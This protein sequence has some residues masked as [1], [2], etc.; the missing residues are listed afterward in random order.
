MNIFHTTQASVVH[1]ATKYPQTPRFPAT[2]AVQILQ[3]TQTY[4]YT[5][6]PSASKCN[7]RLVPA[8]GHLMFRADTESP[9]WMGHHPGCAN[10]L[11][12]LSPFLL[13]WRIS[14]MKM[15][16]NSISGRFKVEVDAVQL[17]IK[18]Q[19]SKQGGAERSGALPPLFFSRRVLHHLYFFS[20][21]E[22]RQV[23][24]ELR[25]GQI[26]IAR[27]YLGWV[28]KKWLKKVISKFGCYIWPGAKHEFRHLLNL[29][30]T[31]AKDVVRHFIHHNRCNSIIFI[32]SFKFLVFI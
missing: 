29:T 7:V 17:H 4:A 31:T 21:I 13:R 23:N 14:Q 28:R 8:A 9:S 27:T 11:S 30:F 1:Y 18:D 32:Y 25:H 24:L 5:R 6:S 10:S 2:T 19:R 3:C 12:Q 26:G 20:R 22:F 16:V 15:Q